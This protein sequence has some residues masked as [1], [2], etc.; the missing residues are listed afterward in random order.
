MR[1][2]VFVAFAFACALAATAFAQ[3][4]VDNDF[5]GP[6]PASWIKAAGSWQVKDGKLVQADS[7]ENMAVLNIP[8]QQS[9]V[10]QYEFDLEYVDGFQD[11]YGGFGIHIL[12]SD[13]SRGRAWGDGTSGL[14]WLA[15]DNLTY[16][17]GIFAQAYASTSLTRMGLYPPRPIADGFEF[18]L[19]DQYVQPEYLS[20]TIP[21]KI[22]VD[23]PGGEIRLYDPLDMNTYYAFSVTIPIS[24]G[25]YFAFRTNSLAAKFDNLKIT[26]LE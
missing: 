18:R 8:C 2:R 7:G 25:S 6:L 24:S 15:M 17:S 9:G 19:P 20:V 26:K 10:M 23:I 3:T 1:K 22:V 11:G 14:L 13:P 21:V 4:I 16:G 5:S 12:V